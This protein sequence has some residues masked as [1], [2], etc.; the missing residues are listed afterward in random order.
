ME[1]RLRTVTTECFIIENL[2]VTSMGRDEDE[3]PWPMAWLHRHDQY[4]S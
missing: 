4:P 3:L 2:D 1:N